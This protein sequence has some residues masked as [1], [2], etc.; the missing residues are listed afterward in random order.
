MKETQSLLTEL[1][2][3]SFSKEVIK[4]ELELEVDDWDHGMKAL[5]TFLNLHQIKNKRINH[6]YEE[7]SLVSKLKEFSF[8]YRRFSFKDGRSHT[9]ETMNYKSKCLKTF[10]DNFFAIGNKSRT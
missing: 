2:D 3:K 10:K 1:W 6:L 8:F 9:T 5:V 7:S 4:F